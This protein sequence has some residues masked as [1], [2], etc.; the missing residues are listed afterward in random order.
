[1]F[2]TSGARGVYGKEITPEFVLKVANAFSEGEVYVG[3]DRR[4]SSPALYHAAVSGALSAGADVF[5]L[6]FAPT[7]VVSF[8]SRKNRAKG[9]M[10]TASH[11]PPEYNGVKLFEDGME[12]TKE[13]AN[14]LLEKNPRYGKGRYS[15]I[16]ASEYV[17]F[18]LSKAEKY[19]GVVGIDGNGVASLITPNVLSKMGARVFAV[20]CFGGFNR[21]PEPNEENLAHLRA[22]GK[23]I[24][25]AHDGDGD[26]VMVYYDG[27]IIP[28]DVLLA[29]MIEEILRERKGTVVSTVE[30]SLCVREAVERMGG[31][32]EITPVGSTYVGEKVKEKNAVF[33]GEPAGEF[34]FPESSL[35]PD[36]IFATVFLLNME[37][38]ER[39]SERTKRFRQYPIVR[40]KYRVGDKEGV[41]ERVKKE[42]DVEGERNETDGVRIDGED[43][44]VLVRPS[45]T[46]PV[47]RVTVEGK[48]KSKVEEI[49]KK[50][51]RIIL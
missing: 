11:N 45:G 20:N 24:V 29:M 8:Y 28:G 42:M 34:I 23:K 49:V 43:Y 14:A 21:R 12:L 32:I 26:R 18:V 37:K 15:E 2:G 50:V 36:G 35:C 51:E 47:L 25:F 7:P 16:D 22:F 40:K 3:V 5:C 46:E 48:E 9:I 27:R 6:G 31:R 1:M 4:E 30:A 33:G 17:E 39:L 13:K 44:W 38:E 10:I 41:M 19:T